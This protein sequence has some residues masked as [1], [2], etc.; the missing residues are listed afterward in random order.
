M[1][2]TDVYDRVGCIYNAPGNYA[3]INGTF[4]SC[5]GENQLPVGHYFEGGV[6]KIWVQPPES[7]GPI[8]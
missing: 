4:Q 7:L 3:A 2:A 6:D 5:K 1:D 8:A